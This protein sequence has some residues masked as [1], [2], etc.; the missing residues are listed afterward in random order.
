MNREFKAP[1]GNQVYKDPKVYLVSVPKVRGG[2]QVFKDPE[3]I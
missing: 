3:G 2:N 1:E